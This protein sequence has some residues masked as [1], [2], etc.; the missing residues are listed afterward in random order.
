MTIAEVVRDLYR[1]E[2]Q[3]EQSYSERQLYEAAVDRMGREVAV[4]QK[5]SEQEA[6][7]LIEQHLQRGPRR[8]AKGETEIAGAEAATSA[9]VIDEAA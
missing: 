8:N 2:A 9:G 6:L 4:V 5:L 7:K 1:S 3:P